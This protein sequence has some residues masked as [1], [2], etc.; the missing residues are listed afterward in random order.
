VSITGDEHRAHS[1]VE[2]YY[3]YIQEQ[4]AKGVCVKL[5]WIIEGENGVRSL[6]NSLPLVQGVD[7][8]INYWI[9]ISDQ[10]VATS[11]NLNHTAYLTAKLIQGFFERTL[12]NPVKLLNGSRIDRHH[13]H[14][15]NMAPEVDNT[16]RGVTRGSESLSSL[17]SYF[18]GVKSNVAKE[19]ASTGMS[20][21]EILQM[22]ESDLVKI[23]GISDKSARVIFDGF[24]MIN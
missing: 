12:P 19:L 17:L 10:Y 6:Y 9:A 24:N 4:A 8:M 23:K 18:P 1:Q 15:T 16:D 20:I 11:F 22:S 5:I 14:S 2:R 13:A 7:G 21:K 3:D